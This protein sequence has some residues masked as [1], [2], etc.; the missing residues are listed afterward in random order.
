[1]PNLDSPSYPTK[2]KCQKSP[3]PL[4]NLVS[5]LIMSKYL[6]T[7]III[8]EYTKNSLKRKITLKR[9]QR[10]MNKCNNHQLLKDFKLILNRR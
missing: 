10:A 8:S 1:M 4:E 2:I 7:F 9:Q 3:S 5:L 6:M